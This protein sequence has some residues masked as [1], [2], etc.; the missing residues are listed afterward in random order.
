MSNREKIGQSIKDDVNLFL[1]SVSSGTIT[2]EIV[3]YA[4]VSLIAA[5][6]LILA[7]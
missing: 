4:V 1:A 5:I 6:V 7:V 2:R 3:I